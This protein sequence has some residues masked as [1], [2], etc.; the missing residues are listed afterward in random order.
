LSE[1]RPGCAEQGTRGTRCGR[2]FTR[3]ALFSGKRWPIRSDS[4]SDLENAS[5]FLNLGRPG[6]DATAGKGNGLHTGGHHRR[7][8]NRLGKKAGPGSPQEARPGGNFS[9]GTQRG[10]LS[11]HVPEKHRGKVG[12]LGSAE[13]HGRGGNGGEASGRGGV[14]RGFGP[15]TGAVAVGICVESYERCG[16]RPRTQGDVDADCAQEQQSKSPR[17]RARQAGLNKRA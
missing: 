1:R 10:V 13:A 7:R 2:S 16:E 17:R 12:A 9:G 5:T 8:R 11:H 6:T 14:F 4:G 3:M 15:E